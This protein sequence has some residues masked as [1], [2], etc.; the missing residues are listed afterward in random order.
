MS[1]HGD[2]R[3]LYVGSTCTDTGM[4]CVRTDGWYWIIKLDEACAR[5]KSEDDY[6]ANTVSVLTAGLGW[7]S[8]FTT[9]SF[10][11]LLPVPVSV[12]TLCG[13][14]KMTSAQIQ[15]LLQPPDE[16]IAI[17]Y[18]ISVLNKTFVSSTLR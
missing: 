11:T 18:A 5:R 6:P 4:W 8:L 16:H 2:E 1:S 12:S 15:A 10:P 9:F 17:E 13:V 14:K 7:N 3:M